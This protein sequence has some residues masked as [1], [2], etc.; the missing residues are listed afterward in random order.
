[1][2]LSC[3]IS[4]PV[5]TPAFFSD[6]WRNTWLYEMESYVSD[7]VKN[8]E[9]K[10]YDGSKD[11]TFENFIKEISINFYDVIFVIA[12]L[13]S[14]DGF[15]KTI[16]Y[17][18][19]LSPSSKIFAYGHSTILHPSYFEQK[20]IDAYPLIG[21]FESAIKAY[22]DYING[23]KDLK[24]IAIKKYDKWIKSDVIS[25]GKMVWK[26]INP[27][28]LDNWDVVRLTVARGCIGNCPF[29]IAPVLHGSK[30]QRKPIHEV[31]DYI[32]KFPEE[33]L[34]INFLNLLLQVLLILETV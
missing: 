15:E 27:K 19:I 1:M 2:K 23:N 7:E 31:L 22:V 32:K 28:Y 9:F 26:F 12:P 30:E 17:I 29:C 10:I 21:D 34:I 5:S 25:Q 20:D 3:L 4:W 11:K 8:A 13:D 24:N 18:R 33:L 6:T 14:M 16:H